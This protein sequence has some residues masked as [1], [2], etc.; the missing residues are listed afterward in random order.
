MFKSLFLCILLALA[1][2]SSVIARQNN[3]P[4]QPFERL[5]LSPTPV[6]DVEYRIGQDDLLEVSVYGVPSLDTTVRVSANGRVTFPPVGVIT[7]AGRTSRDLELEIENALRDGLF[8]NSPQVSVFVDD[9]GSQPVAVLGAVREPDIY[10]IRGRKFLL[11]MLAMAGGL[12]ERAGKTIQV[13]RKTPN[14]ASTG[15]EN[16]FEAPIVIDVQALFVRGRTDFNILIHA[17]DTINVPEAGSVFVVGEVRSPGEYILRNGR[18]VTVTQALALGG[19]FGTDPKQS[20][21]FIT[22]HYDDG[23][24]EELSIDLD[25]IIKN[26]AEDI[27]MQPNDILFVPGSPTKAGLKRALD[28]AVS[29]VTSRLIWH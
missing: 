13:I 1:P 3:G 10:Q 11:D 5:S 7:A 22:R 4:L 23:T 26:Q 15:G 2:F 21:A 24:K 16:P 12:D 8:V 29:V 17:G 25:K 6:E 18:N 20:E 19:G 9:Y 14:A 28:A 27:T